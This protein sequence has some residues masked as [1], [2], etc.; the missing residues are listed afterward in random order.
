MKLKIQRKKGKE[1]RN[2]KRG[3]LLL[4]KRLDSKMNSSNKFSNLTKRAKMQNPK[5]RMIQRIAMCRAMTILKMMRITILTMIYWS[6]RIKMTNKLIQAQKVMARILLNQR[7][8]IKRQA[9]LTSKQML[10]FS[11]KYTVIKLT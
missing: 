9:D 1:R 4:K 3:K 2:L 6:K 11:S 7:K 10:I 8:I 5:P